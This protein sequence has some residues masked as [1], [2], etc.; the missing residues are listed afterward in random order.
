MNA[1]P[2]RR[3]QILRNMH[4]WEQMTPDQREQ[5]RQKF[6]QQREQRRLDQQDRRQRRQTFRR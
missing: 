6:R 2:E 5:M 1:N 4:R 3:A